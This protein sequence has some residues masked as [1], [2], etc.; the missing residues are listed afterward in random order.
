MEI[1]DEAIEKERKVIKSG[2]LNKRSKLLRKWNR[3][4]CILTEKYLFTFDG[5]NKE[6]KCTNSFE[7]KKCTG[8]ES[9]DSEVK[10]EESFGFVDGGNENNSCIFFQAESKKDKEEW[11]N[12]LKK[13][14]SHYKD[15]D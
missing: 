1:E 11:M 5:V 15:I 4:Y 6:A 3:R 14:I 12:I 2:F 13:Y 10:K 7:L 9:K 8:L